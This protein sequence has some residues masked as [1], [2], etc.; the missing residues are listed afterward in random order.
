MV[1]QKKCSLDPQIRTK[2]CESF[3]MRLSQSHTE[4]DLLINSL[5]Q[6]K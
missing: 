4:G 2:R 5:T 6:A 3:K 1:L